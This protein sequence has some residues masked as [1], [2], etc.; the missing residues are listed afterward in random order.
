MIQE[1]G[2]SYKA[3]HQSALFQYFTCKCPNFR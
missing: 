2:L 1:S 3:A